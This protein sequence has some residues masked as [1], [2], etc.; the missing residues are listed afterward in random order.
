MRWDGGQ[1]SCGHPHD[2]LAHY[3]GCACSRAHRCVC[4]LLP[5]LLQVQVLRRQLLRLIHV[6][7]FAP[8]ATFRV[9]VV[10]RCCLCADE[11]DEAAWVYVY[12]LRASLLTLPHLPPL[13]VPAGPLPHAGAAGRHLPHLPGLPGPGPVQGPAGGG[14]ADGGGGGAAAAAKW[15]W[16]GDLVSGLR[17]FGPLVTHSPPCLSMQIQARH[18]E[19]SACGGQRDVEALEQ[20]LCGMLQQVGGC[21]SGPGDGWV[22]GCPLQRP[23][24]A[25]RP[26]RRAPRGTSC[27]TCAASS[28]PAWHATTCS[29]AATCAA[30]TSGARWRR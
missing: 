12:P 13:P 8:E 23:A 27:R 16:E 3:P 9:R 28:V 1:P 2:V 6:K 15:L 7:E 5:L 25:P 20:R 30:G 21:G 14:G 26:P 10:W 4:L 17:T 18:W 29:R 22:A 24:L 11:A 19:C